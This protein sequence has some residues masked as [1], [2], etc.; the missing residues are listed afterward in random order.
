[1]SESAS[2]QGMQQVHTAPFTDMSL[3]QQAEMMASAE[4]WKPENGDEIQG[5]VVGVKVGTSD[6]REASG[7][8][9]RYPI[10]FVRTDDKV[11][12]VH[13]FQTILENEIKSARPKIGEDIYI[14]CIGATGTAKI[15]GQSP[16]VRYAVAV[17]REGGDTA[18]VWDSLK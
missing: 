4:G 5:T 11:V 13:C 14:K 2:E 9:P 10:V 7:R 8:D 12:A 17:Q 15:K 3:A 6:Q 1:M 16:P 18:D